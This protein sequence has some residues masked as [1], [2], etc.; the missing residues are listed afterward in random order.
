V[1]EFSVAADKYSAAVMQ[2]HARLS[3]SPKEYDRLR[4][5][6]E[7]VRL[8]SEEARLALERHAASHGC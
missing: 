6:A 4:F 1:G 7:A 8:A 2:L 3:V 5:A